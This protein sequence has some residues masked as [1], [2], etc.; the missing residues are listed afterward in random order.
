MSS[1][2]E[3]L[4]R[5]LAGL[6]TRHLRRQLSEPLGIDFSSNDYLGLAADERFAER[7][8]ELTA[9][10]ELTAPA[11]RL[12]RGNRRVHRELE[13]E[14][15][16]W[17]GTEDAL[18][19]STG[20]QANLGVVTAL[21]GP[22]DRVLSDRLNHASLIDA[23]RLSGARREVYPHLDLG[24]IERLLVTPWPGGRTFV[25]TESY[26]SMDGDVAPLDRIADLADA[27][28]ASLIVDDAHATG[29]WGD[30]RGS[31][32]TEVFGIADRAEA[33][34]STFGKALGSFGAFVAAPRVV[35]EWLVNRARS[36]IFTTAVPPL[37]LAAMRA[38]VELTEAAHLRRADLQRRSDDLRSRLRAAGHDCLESTGP[39]VPV[40]LGDNDRALRVAA[41]LQARGL[42]VRAIRPPSVAPGT[43]RLRISVHADHDDGTIDRLARELLDVLPTPQQS[44]Q[45]P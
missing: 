38:G 42:D 19:F 14:L 28:D 21:A 3:E 36:F 40:V 15:A 5:S 2:R 23:V 29:V 45:T 32:L 17:K 34:T 22:R 39:I 7:V 26:F 18:V 1:L 13:S 37:L 43:A 16:S 33:I 6:S 25:L 27:C 30:E 24:E 10:G 4:A 31:G 41:E 44:R 20:Y 12:L 9:S 11:S 35:V 8:R